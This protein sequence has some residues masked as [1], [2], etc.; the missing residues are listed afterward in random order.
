MPS[1][2]L[3]SLQ[4]IL[5]LSGIPFHLLHTY[6]KIN[7]S[8]WLSDCILILLRNFLLQALPFPHATRKHR[9]QSQL[10]LSLCHYYSLSIPLLWHL[11]LSLCIIN[12]IYSNLRILWLKNV[13]VILDLYGAPYCP[14]NDKYIFN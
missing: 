6:E 12:F 14:N 2:T 10:F 9:I 5:L 4:I 3:A 13:H 1:Y 8:I 7:T 11:E